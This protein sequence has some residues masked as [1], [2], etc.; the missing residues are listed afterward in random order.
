MVEQTTTRFT[1]ILPKLKSEKLSM[2]FIQPHMVKHFGKAACIFGYVS[3]GYP[4]SKDIG[5]EDVLTVL[6]VDR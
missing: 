5:E 2:H 6:E 1:K 4:L 3:R